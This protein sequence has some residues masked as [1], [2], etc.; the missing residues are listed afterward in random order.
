MTTFQSQLLYALGNR[1]KVLHELKKVFVRPLI[2][3]AVKAITE[4]HIEEGILDRISQKY[5][6]P[7]ESVDEYYSVIYTILKVHLGRLSQNVKPT[8]FKQT[9]DELNLSSDCIEDLST[10]IYGQ[11]R[12]ELLTGL[13]NRTKFY[14]HLISCKWHVD[15]I[16]SSSILNRVL[17]PHILMEWTF[18]NGERQ[19]FEL[20][21][22]KFH[23]LRHTVATLLVEM[24]KVEQQCASKNICS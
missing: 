10:V 1:T 3:I 11:K 6:I 18:N 9:L 12:P 7:E 13:I 22:S 23:Q 2:Q 14:A 16:I 8:E 5:N 17:E 15:I 4:E 19:I 21:M 24:Q 20:S